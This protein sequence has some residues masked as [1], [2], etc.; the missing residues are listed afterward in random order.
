MIT[1]P[2][3]NVWCPSNNRYT[4]TR[5]KVASAAREE[6][7]KARLTASQVSK[8]S[9]PTVRSIPSR[10]PSAVATPFP[11]SKLKKIGYR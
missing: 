7:L 4:G 6:R 9:A 3:A 11:P 1:K 8:A 5:A 10:A 2:T